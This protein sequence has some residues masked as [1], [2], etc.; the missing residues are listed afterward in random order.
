MLPATWLAGLFPF[1]QPLVDPLWE[2]SFSAFD[3]VQFPLHFS[4]DKTQTS[5]GFRWGYVFVLQS[6]F[7]ARER[8][9]I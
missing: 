9:M 5:L 2:L 7:Y 6:Y 8:L 4:V 3:F 1:L